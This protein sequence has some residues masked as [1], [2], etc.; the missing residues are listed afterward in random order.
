MKQAIAG[1]S[2]ASLDEATVMT[3]WPTIAASGAGQM[4]GRLCSLGGEGPFAIGKLLAPL[5]ILPALALFFISIVPP[6]PFWFV[7]F[8]RRYKV[9][10][11]RILV[12][13]DCLEWV[14][15]HPFG[16][17]FPAQKIRT[18][19]AKA[20]QLDRF[21]T[22]EIEVLP[23]QEWFPAG[24]LIFKQGAV[25]TFRLS[26]VS[27]PEAFRQVCLKARNSFVLVNQALKQQI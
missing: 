11:R 21:D 15:Y 14:V 7:R 20:V 12:L 13:E 1:V 2:P 9:T 3:V 19:E 27:R 6:F 26:G 16:F 8:N 22:I 4:I 23:G 5:T 18:E 10:N 17:R 25:E 24:E